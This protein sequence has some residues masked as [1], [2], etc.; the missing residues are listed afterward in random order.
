MLLQESSCVARP[1]GSTPAGG[2]CRLN[3]PICVLN[4]QEEIGVHPR[5][6]QTSTWQPIA[7]SAKKSRHEL[8]P[9]I[10][11]RRFLVPTWIVV[12]LAVDIILPLFSHPLPSLEGVPL[13]PLR[14]HRHGRRYRQRHHPLHS[15]PLCL[16]RAPPLAGRTLVRRIYDNIFSQRKHVTAIH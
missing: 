8:T 14:G 5:G 12:S 15:P 16:G 3:D 2:E 11:V 7:A 6:S 13:Y 1:V 9:L 10:A 4:L